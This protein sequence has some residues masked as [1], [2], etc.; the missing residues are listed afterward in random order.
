MNDTYNIY[1]AGEVLPDHDGADVRTRMAKLFNAND[2]TLD[3][4]FSGK[5]QL[6]KRDCDKDTALKYK[7]AMERAGA[8]PIIARAG[9]T[10]G[11]SDAPAAPAGT[12]NKP[13]PE[14]MSAAERIAAVAQGKDPNQPHAPASL[15]LEPA[16]A[17]VLRP[18]ERAPQQAADID[19]SG[20]SVDSTA[21]RLSEAS[22]PPPSA[23]DT[24]HISMGSVGEDIPTLDRGEAPPP[25]DTSGLDLTPEGTDFSD[26]SE[27]E[28]EAL[29]LDLSAI[30][31]APEGSA[32]LDDAFRKSEQATPPDTDH[33][34]L[35]D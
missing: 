5:R 21:E 7:Q 24:S 1:F 4:L 29:D 13:A 12:P 10:A 2:A 18:D 19:T 11:A 3:K 20:L 9:E 27:R 30:A 22:A 16:G 28:V 35:E 33:L 31:L 26:L 15:H 17:D 23:P 25:P 34:S 6:I 14:P 8:K 32:V